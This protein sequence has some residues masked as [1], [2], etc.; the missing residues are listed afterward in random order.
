MPI[1]LPLPV[2]HRT[3]PK[4][5]RPCLT[6][7]DDEDPPQLGAAV[8]GGAGLVAHP[9]AGQHSDEQEDGGEAQHGGGDHQRS[10]RLDIACRWGEKEDL[11]YL[12]QKEE[13]FGQ[14][15]LPQELPTPSQSASN[16]FCGST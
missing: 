3:I 5:R 14:A 6:Q 9:D 7:E 2:T 10:A 16:G 15:L 13:N 11:G 8:L 12:A 4:Q 1:D